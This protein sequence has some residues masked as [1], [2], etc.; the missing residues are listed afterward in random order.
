MTIYKN[1]KKLF[2]LGLSLFSNKSSALVP[3]SDTSSLVDKKASDLMDYEL[4]A[5]EDVISQYN[6]GLLSILRQNSEVP[7]ISNIYSSYVLQ[8]KESA[9]RQSIEEDQ[10]YSLSP[11]HRVHFWFQSKVEAQKLAMNH[12]QM[13]R[14]FI[15]R[16][17]DREIRN[18][19]QDKQSE[20]RKV[21]LNS[22]IKA[23]DDQRLAYS[24]NLQRRAFHYASLLLSK[25]N[26]TPHSIGV[27]LKEDF[28]AGGFDFVREA[29]DLETK[30][31]N[32]TVTEDLRRLDL[33]DKESS[34]FKALFSAFREL[35][36][37]DQAKKSNAIE[38]AKKIVRDSEIMVGRGIKNN[39]LPSISREKYVQLLEERRQLIKQLEN[40]DAN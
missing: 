12:E 20:M 14:E 37:V 34:E 15:E 5:R 23:I 8:N 35:K 26:I 9:V 19:L 25:H 13:F 27:V 21:E 32:I 40:K 16:D 24:N 33:E 2:V 36:A 29:H 7:S 6:K 22:Q 28:K 10:E 11:I 39:N 4:L 31:S 30:Q 18:I 3:D 17:Y 1:I 38:E